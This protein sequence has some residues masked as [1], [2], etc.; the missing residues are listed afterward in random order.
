MYTGGLQMH[1]IGSWCPGRQSIWP[2]LFPQPLSRGCHTRLRIWDEQA[3]L[4]ILITRW[5]SWG[6][7]QWWRPL[8]VL[9]DRARASFCR[10]RPSIKPPET[11]SWTLFFQITRID[12]ESEMVHFMPPGEDEES[13]EFYAD[14][15]LFCCNAKWQICQRDELFQILACNMGIWTQ[16]PIVITKFG[17]CILL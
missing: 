9:R 7:E 15:L 3:C 16:A 2:L 11:W 17:Q 8:T 1:H 12:E 5:A 4:S 14:E 13:I 10:C 6:G